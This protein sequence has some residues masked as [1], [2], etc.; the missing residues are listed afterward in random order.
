MARRR[1]RRVNPKY[2]SRRKG[3]FKSVFEFAV[4]TA[5]KPY[6]KEILYEP[7]KL[8]YV[9]EATY[10][11]DFLVTTKS[12]KTFFLETKGW[13]DTASRTKM[14]WVKQAHPELDIRILFMKNSK[15]SIAANTK[16]AI[17]HGYK[18]AVE[19]IPEE[20]LLE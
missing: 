15:K 3:R 10:T 12:G 11:P 7:E 8:T 18:H 19:K 20:W 13:F 5:V 1:T 17:A 2:R 6:V 14:A 9:V 4:F 16:W